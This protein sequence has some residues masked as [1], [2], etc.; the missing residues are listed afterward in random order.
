MQK[1]RDFPRGSNNR[2]VRSLPAPRVG[3]P[4]RTIRTSEPDKGRK[5]LGA[6][7]TAPAGKRKKTAGAGDSAGEASAVKKDAVEQ[8]KKKKSLSKPAAS[9]RFKV[10]ALASRPE[11]DVE[12][13]DAPK[14]T[15]TVPIY[16]PRYLA[17]PEDLEVSPQ[18]I[19]AAAPELLGTNMDFVREALPAFAS[20][21]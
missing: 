20:R 8:A 21:Y 13:K 18:A 9:V 4:P 17:R 19:E 6:A 2:R 5:R 16:L 3:V 10:S 1:K 12:M 14:E 11:T 15:R 7:V